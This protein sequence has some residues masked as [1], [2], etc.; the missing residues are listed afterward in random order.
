MTAFVPDYR[1]GAVP[2]FHRVPLLVDA[3]LVGA[4]PIEVNDGR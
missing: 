4:L 3:L 1:C 2:E